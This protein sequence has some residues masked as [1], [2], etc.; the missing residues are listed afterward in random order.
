M[1]QLLSTKSRA[2]DITYIHTLKDGWCYLA[3]VID[4]YS[5]K[6]IGYFV[7]K[8]IDTSLALQAIKNAVRLQKPTKALILHSDLRC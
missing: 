3:S 4:L 5:S 6:I 7:S 8:V 2:A 1:K